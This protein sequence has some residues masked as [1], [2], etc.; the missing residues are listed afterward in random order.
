MLFTKWFTKWSSD[1]RAARRLD[2][3]RPIANLFNSC[4]SWSIPFSLRLLNAS[5]LQIKSA[6]KKHHTQF[7]MDSK[8]SIHFGIFINHQNSFLFI[9]SSFKRISHIWHRRPKS[10]HHR[11]IEIHKVLSMFLITLWIDAIDWMSNKRSTSS[12]VG[13]VRLACAGRMERMVADV[14]PTFFASQQYCSILLACSRRSLFVIA[15]LLVHAV[16]EEAYASRRLASAQVMQQFRIF[17][18]IK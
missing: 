16:F 12:F 18:R 3:V 15:S 7:T 17:L 1:C 8:G 13:Q 11:T 6:A 14:C 4:S 5:V 2:S 10:S 9:G